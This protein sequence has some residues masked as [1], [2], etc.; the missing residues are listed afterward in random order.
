MNDGPVIVSTDHLEDIRSCWRTLISSDPDKWKDILPWEFPQHATRAVEDEFLLK[1]FSESEVEYRGGAHGEGNGF[2]FLK[3]VWYNLAIWNAD[4]KIPAIAD[5]WIAQNQDVV[6]DAGM[7]EH[8][9]KEGAT[10]STFAFTPEEVA[11]YG[12]KLLGWAIHNIQLRF[13]FKHVAGQPTDS[14]IVST[15]KPTPQAIDSAS[16]LT[17]QVSDANA[18]VS[19]T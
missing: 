6:G 5:A 14:A 12:E 16:V 4:W 1:W 13:R 9:C 10:L 11:M 8:V 3:Q 15:E 17:A 19:S 18:S 7:L 2:R